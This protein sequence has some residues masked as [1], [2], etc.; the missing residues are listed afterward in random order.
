MKAHEILRNHFEK[1]KKVKGYSLRALARDLA[2]SAP[3]ISNVLAGKKGIPLAKLATLARLL[4]IDPQTLQE[5][6]SQLVG[7][8]TPSAPG[9]ISSWEPSEKKHLSALRQWYYIALLEMTSCEGFKNDP[10]EIAAKLGVSH[11]SVEV[12]LRE[13][14][15]M[16]LLEQ[17]KG[18]LRKTTDHLRL[19][20][21]QALEDVRSFHR[22]MLGKAEKEL[23]KT[24]AADFE[25]R[26]I[27]GITVTASPEKIA[28]AK[29]MLS[30][31]LH[32]IANFLIEEKGS[33]VYHLSGQLF[34]LTKRK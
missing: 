1:K 11:Q 15:S 20:S 8:K 27:T 12:A 32:Q 25:Q 24:E 33:E 29:Q 22:Q 13:L 16:G 14:V 19:G 34:P 9:P 6:K 26:L 10:K 31:S 5:I 18:T 30:D 21:L 23:H 4:D 3:F 28:V 2:V 7:A 17:K